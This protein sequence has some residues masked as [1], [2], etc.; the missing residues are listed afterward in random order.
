MNFSSDTFIG[1]NLGGGVFSLSGYRATGMGTAGVGGAAAGG[2]G[3]G[4]GWSRLDRPPSGAA[5]G[6]A[7]EADCLRNLRG[8][9]E[10]PRDLECRD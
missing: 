6:L 9:R 8:E 1:I 3:L 7:G 5:A 2:A 10:R 4:L